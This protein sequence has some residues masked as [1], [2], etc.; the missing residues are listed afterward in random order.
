MAKDFYGYDSYRTSDGQVFNV[1]GGYSNAK[2]SAEEHQ[3]ELDRAGRSSGPDAEAKMKNEA[4]GYYMAKN[5][6]KAISLYNQIIEKGGRFKSV[7]LLYRAVCYYY[8]S[9][10]K[11]TINDITEALNLGGFSDAMKSA[12]FYLR[13]WAYG[14]KGKDDESKSD[15]KQS[16]DLALGNQEQVGLFLAEWR[17]PYKPNSGSSSSSSSSSKNEN[18]VVRFFQA[19]GFEDIDY[20]GL[21][22][23]IPVSIL[24]SLVITACITFLA[25][26]FIPQKMVIVGIVSLV[27]SFLAFACTHKALRVILIIIAAIGLAFGVYTFVSP[28]KS[29]LAT[30][31]SQTATATA[32]VNANV[33]F[34]T[35]PTTG[36]NIIRQLQQGDTVTLTGETNGSWT[37]IKH[38][39]DTGWI[40][41]EFLTQTAPQKSGSTTQTAAPTREQ[42]LDNLIGEYKGT[43]NA[44][45]GDTGLTLTVFKDGSNYKATFD[46]YNLPGKSNADEGKYYMNVTYNTSSKKY[47]LTGYEWIKQPWGY[48]FANLE[49][50]LNGNVLSGSTFNFKVTRN[51]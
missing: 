39:S 21:E 36:D 32:T 40:S 37:Q 20:F 45:Q 34:R 25:Y 5:Y 3:R 47:T 15:F 1:D 50:T 38:G 18:P 43:Y 51:N 17:I 46:F 4:D 2:L 41:T 29:K 31:Q 30:T 44:G 6:D 42:A 24:L 16:A 13:A 19:I 22:I 27:L 26:L 10:Q 8:T 35:E 11:G 14:I 28:S 9:Y 49:G 33:N 23:N 12:A 7:A 48:T